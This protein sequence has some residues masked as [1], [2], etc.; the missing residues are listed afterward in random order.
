[1]NQ[2]QTHDKARH[3]AQ[4][5][6]AHDITQRLLESSGRVRYGFVSVSLKIHDGRIVDVTH[7]ETQSMRE[8]QGTGGITTMRPNA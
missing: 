3:G 7:T 6:D 5:R 4:I 1:M 2:S 8:R